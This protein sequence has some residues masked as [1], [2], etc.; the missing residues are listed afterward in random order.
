MG[1]IHEIL[2]N[3]A[4]VSPTPTAISSEFWNL[5]YQLIFPSQIF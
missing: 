1:V 2:R 5:A 4:Y 3:F